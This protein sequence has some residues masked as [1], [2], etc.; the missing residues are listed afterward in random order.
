[1]LR[2]PFE[3][4]V[5]DPQ[6][7]IAHV[8]AVA[9]CS[10]LPGKQLFNPHHAGARGLIRDVLLTTKTE[11]QARCVLQQTHIEHIICRDKHTTHWKPGSLTV[12][13]LKLSF[14][15]S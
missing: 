8:D 5:V 9:F 13:A 4:R 14:I 7:D 3:G 15:T 11:A 1:M 10:R 6:D 2:E 12:G